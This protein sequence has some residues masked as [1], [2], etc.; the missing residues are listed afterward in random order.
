MADI[1]P[2]ATTGSQ[3]AIFV[4]ANGNVGLSISQPTARLDVNG[5]V[6]M[7]GSLAAG[8]VDVLGTG[9]AKLSVQAG[10]VDALVQADDAG[11]RGSPTGLVI[12]TSSGH[13]LSFG[14]SA[15]TRMTI[16]SD[17]NVGIGTGAASP[18]AKL[19]IAGNGGTSVDLL[20]NGRLRSNNPNGGLWVSSD[21]FVGGDDQTGTNYIGFW[22]SEVGWALKVLPNG[23][24]GIGTAYQ[25]HPVMKLDVVG[26]ASISGNLFVSG[27]IVYL[28]KGTDNQG[29]AGWKNIYWRGGNWAGS[30][31]TTGPTVISGINPSD[32]RLKTDVRP[33]GHALET[34]R[35]LRGVRFRWGDLGLSHFTRDIETACPPDRVPLRS[36][37]GRL[38]RSSSVKRSRRWPGAASAW[39]RRTWKRSCP[40][41]STRMGTATST[42]A[43]S[44]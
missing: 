15:A 38:W 19:E 34:I 40:N 26:D 23:N 25:D 8:T 42:S 7:R 39:S 22:T 43:T 27:T 44:T 2:T 24:V 11:L 4:D 37:T 6:N 32:L 36:R 16:S 21:R 14:T 31:D 1:G 29:Q 12:G 3:D 30:T 33:V 41:W 17:S 28:D 10:N 5:N 13:A 35:T 9:G 18:R 20:V